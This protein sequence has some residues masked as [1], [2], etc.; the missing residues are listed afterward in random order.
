MQDVQMSAIHPTKTAY[1]GLHR[2]SSKDVS[3]KFSEHS[4]PMP[5]HITARAE[6]EVSSF[7]TKPGSRYPRPILESPPHTTPTR[8]FTRQH[9]EPL[10]A[11]RE[12]ISA[13]LCCD[14]KLP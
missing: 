3:A 10:S 14:A 9:R 1:P 5:G 12:N 13:Q 8:H 2:T 7:A 6:Y 4:A 11:C